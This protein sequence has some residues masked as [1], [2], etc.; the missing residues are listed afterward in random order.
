MSDAGDLFKDD[1]PA[2]PSAVGSS[3]SRSGSA[4][5]GL[6]GDDSPRASPNPLEYGENDDEGAGGVAYLD[7]SIS[8]QAIPQ[9][10]HMAPS[11]GKVWHLKLPTYVNVESR[12]F[13]VE[14]YRATLGDEPTDLTPNEAKAKMINV[15]NTMRWRWVTGPDGEPVRQSNARMLRWSDGSVS[16]QLGADLFDV[17]PS[18]G[19]TL[20]RTGA[21]DA[22]PSRGTTFVGA[23]V[24]TGTGLFAVEAAVTGALSLVPTSM[25]SKTHLELV[26]HVE[27]RHVKHSRMKML[28]EGVDKTTYNQMIAKANGVAPAAKTARR[29]A[30]RR[31]APAGDRGR[32]RAAKRDTDSG[33]E[34]YVSDEPRRASGRDRDRDEQA[35]YD[36]DDGFVVADSDSEDERAAHKRAGKRR[37]YDTDSDEDEM[38]A[39]E[40]RIEEA[41][42][43]AATASGGGGGK[44]KK[45]AK[46]KDY[47]SSE[48]DAEGEEDDAEGEEDADMDI[49]SEGE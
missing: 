29:P 20:A 31:A 33:S 30:R 38:E 13:D 37:K 26:R 8:T 35:D 23:Q 7:E 43:R 17:A 39:A 9:W 14:H 24:P 28:D 40:R 11:D 36:E 1:S 32:P 10:T 15:R 48:D 18:H 2:P 47:V 45:S 5:A 22:A 21:A 19:A 4:D 49:E 44:G 6:F 42:R 12:P 34:G 27:Q 46:S 25:D 3:R 41:E 16:M